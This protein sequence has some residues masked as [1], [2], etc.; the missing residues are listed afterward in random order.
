[1]R[2]IEYLNVGRRG[3]GPASLYTNKH[4]HTNTHTHTHTHTQTHTHTYIKNNVTTIPKCFHPDS[5]HKKMHIK[6][7]RS[8]LSVFDLLGNFN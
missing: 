8:R 5:A 6:L 2:M 1:V 7:I 3:P 4:T